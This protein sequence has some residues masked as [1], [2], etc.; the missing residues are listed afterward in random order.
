MRNRI[1]THG[2]VM[3]SLILPR[4]AS[5]QLD[6]LECEG[7]SFPNFCFMAT[8]SLPPLQFGGAAW[9]DLDGDG[10]MDLVLTG[11]RGTRSEPQP[12]LEAYAN[13]GEDLILGPP[14]TPT[15]PPS[16]TYVTRYSDVGLSATLGF[17]LW[18]GFPA[19]ADYDADGDLDIA[20]SGVG[21]AGGGVTVV[22]N[23]VG[24]GSMTFEVADLLP[25]LGSSSLAWT[26]IDNDGDLDLVSSG[27]DESGETSLYVF[28]NQGDGVFTFVDT[29]LEGAAHGRIVPGDVDG[30]G[31]ADLLVSGVLGGEQNIVRIY[32]NEGGTFTDSQAGLPAALFAAADWAD[33]DGDGDLDI[34]ISGG[35]LSP[36]VMRGTTRVFRNDDFSFFEVAVLDGTLHGTVLW[37]DFD[38]DGDVDAIASGAERISGDVL[39]RVFENDGGSFSPAERFGGGLFG[40]MAAG[41]YDGDGDVDFLLTGVLSTVGTV[42]QEYR[43]EIPHENAPPSA[44]IGLAAVTV[45]SNTTFSWAAASDDQTPGPGL[46]YN[47]RIGTAPGAND[48]MPSNAATDGRRLVTARGNVD[49]NLERTIGGLESGTYYWAV[50]AIDSGGNGSAFSTENVLVVP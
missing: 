31:D 19:L 1:L 7:Q 2:L 39:A 32:L 48:V 49:H 21:A 13:L 11:N 47:L 8:E 41:D 18:D 27:T 36:F 23:N 10:D 25:G 43:N 12:H 46:T 34:L 42:T 24:V 29:G 9:G 50:Q 40:D 17:A 6:P 5:A 28:E 22:L 37:A 3:V 44:P 15:G 38:S 26:D 30:D 14:N 4:L 45:G 33:Y 35:Q 20:V 16:T